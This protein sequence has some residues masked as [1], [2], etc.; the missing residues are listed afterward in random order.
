M[1]MAS[2]RLVRYFCRFSSSMCIDPQNDSIGAAPALLGVPDRRRGQGRTF[3]SQGDER[4]RQSAPGQ[5][6]PS[7]TRSGGPAITVHGEPP[8]G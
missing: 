1:A 7:V 6:S 4:Y 5:S 2:S 8:G 3:T